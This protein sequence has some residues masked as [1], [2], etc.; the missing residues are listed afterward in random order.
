MPNAPRFLKK[1]VKEKLKEEKLKEFD[2]RL[3]VFDENKI[4]ELINKK[5]GNSDSTTK[6]DTPIVRSPVLN[7][8]VGGTVNGSKLR[9]Q[10]SSTGLRTSK[11]HK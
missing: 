2:T 9:R 8:K 1:V 7:R 6:S 4:K 5:F 11:K 3:K 10:A